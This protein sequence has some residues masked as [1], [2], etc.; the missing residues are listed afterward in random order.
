M[1]LGMNPSFFPPPPPPPVTFPP[2]ANDY[3]CLNVLG[4][5]LPCGL[6]SKSRRTALVLVLVIVL[7]LVHFQI[8]ALSLASYSTNFLMTSLF[9]SKSIGFMS[10][11]PCC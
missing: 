3:R 8:L 4:R 11:A 1:W 2:A 5:H 10:A 6:F 7:V 9:N